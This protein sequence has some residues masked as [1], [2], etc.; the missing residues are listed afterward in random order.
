M[1]VTYLEIY[2]F[3]Y[4]CICRDV[5]CVYSFSLMFFQC[6]FLYHCIN[7]THEK[8]EKKC[9]RYCLAALTYKLIAIQI[10]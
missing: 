1:Q 9:N 10:K 7:K 6:C 3:I 2:M 5:I 8:K 4:V